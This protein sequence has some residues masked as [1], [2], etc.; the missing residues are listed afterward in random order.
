MR[1]EIYRK[2]CNMTKCLNTFVAHCS[3]VQANLTE[4]LF[5]RVCAIRVFTM[6]TRKSSRRTKPPIKFADYEMD[7][8]PEDLATPQQI[9]DAVKCEL[10]QVESMIK[11]LS[12]TIED[13]RNHNLQLEL[14]R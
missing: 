2:Y 8:L 3:F 6:D 13:L 1:R 4:S 5:S 12:L 9:S 14:D 11:D 10:S 7:N